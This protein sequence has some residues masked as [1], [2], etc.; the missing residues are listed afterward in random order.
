MKKYFVFKQTDKYDICRES[1]TDDKG[2]E[3]YNVLDLYDC[4]EDATISRSL[5]SCSK[6]LKLSSKLEHP[7]EVEYITVPSDAYLED[8]ID[9]FFNKAN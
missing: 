5:L 2:H 9:E 4:P 8:Y 3:F 1:L 6:L 7:Y